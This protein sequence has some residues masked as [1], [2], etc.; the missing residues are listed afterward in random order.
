MLVLGQMR[1]ERRAPL[2]LNQL[3]VAAGLAL[4][5]A[6]PGG[7][8]GLVLA[9]LVPAY[10]LRGGVEA[11][12]PISRGRLAYWVGPH[13]LNLG[14]GVMDTASQLARSV[15]PVA[16]GVLY[17]RSPALPLV[18]GLAALGVTLLVTLALP[19]RRPAQWLEAQAALSPD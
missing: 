5:L 8:G 18:A 13:G 1:P 7:A 16:A 19:Q 17:A 15:A 14:F 4:L 9:G 3:M 2:V 11:V 6:V 10:F 12:W